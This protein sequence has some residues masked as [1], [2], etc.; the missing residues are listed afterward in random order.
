MA[1]KMFAA[2]LMQL[3]AQYEMQA[4]A[5]RESGATGLWEECLGKAADA[6]AVAAAILPTCSHWTRWKLAHDVLRL[7]NEKEEGDA[8]S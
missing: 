3:G 2:S 1:E 6:K 7:V 4:K 5:A 8:R